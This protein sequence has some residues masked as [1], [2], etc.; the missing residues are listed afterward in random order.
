[1]EGQ[2]RD[3]CCALIRF[4]ALDIARGVQQVF[5]CTHLPALGGLGETEVSAASVILV[6]R[7]TATKTAEVQGGQL[8]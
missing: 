3:Y 5:R 2:N 7:P 4:G 6:R 1:M 8:A